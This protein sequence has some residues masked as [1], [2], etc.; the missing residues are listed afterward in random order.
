M[1]YRRRAT[2]VGAVVV[3][4]AGTVVATIALSRARDNF[5]HA[6]QR[7][8]TVGDCVAV[9]PTTPEAVQAQRSSCA[10][11][12][13][14]TVGALA[15]TSGECPT[16]EYQRFPAP[17]AEHEIAGLCLVPNLV[18]DHCYRLDMPV[19]VV[20]RA[21]CA[22]SGAT[23]DSGV[24]VQITRRLDIH[25]QHACSS[26]GGNFVWPYPSPARTYCTKTL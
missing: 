2:V 7:P 6:A 11:D 20:E 26:G 18:A 16:A 19:G 1:Q 12:P 4:A 5:E 24:L 23:P 17:V 15:D 3:L 8:L 9:L 14:Y 10:E 25:D 22:D 13:S 21:D